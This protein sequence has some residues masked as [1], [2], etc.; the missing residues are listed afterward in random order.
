MRSVTT[1]TRATVAASGKSAPD[2]ILEFSRIDSV[3]ALL[4]PSSVGAMKSPNAR[5]NAKLNAKTMPIFADGMT[6]EKTERTLPAPRLF[7]ASTRSRSTFTRLS[8]VSSVTSGK[9]SVMY[10]MSV[11]NGVPSIP[12]GPSPTSA[13][14]LLMMPSSARMSCHE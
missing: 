4:E 13:S 5:M 6:T 7:A 10:P 3:T 11:A 14:A 2:L 8:R 1:I 12:I 9:N